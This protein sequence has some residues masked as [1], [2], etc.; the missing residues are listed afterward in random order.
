MKKSKQIKLVLISAALASC[1]RS[2]V[3][4]IPVTNIPEPADTTLT[5]GPVYKEDPY[6]NT[7]NL[8]CQEAYWE[9]WNYSFNPF[10]LVYI[11]PPGPGYYYP[12]KFYRRGAFWR[13][14]HF[15]VR[16]GWG[17]SSSSASS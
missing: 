2:L 7:F 1:N 17:K 15:I 10:G 6:P 4:Q 12:G 14:N 5:A 13:N 8:C 16:G 11:G 3:P 9:L